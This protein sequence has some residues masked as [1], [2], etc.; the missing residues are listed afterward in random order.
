MF[1]DL[2]KVS[3]SDALSSDVKCDRLRWLYWRGLAGRHKA[4]SGFLQRFASISATAGQMA[5]CSHPLPVELLLDRWAFPWVPPSCLGLGFPRTANEIASG[6]TWFRLVSSDRRTHDLSRQRRQRCQ[7][8]QSGRACKRDSLPPPTLESGTAEPTV[9]CATGLF[10]SVSSSDH[11][12]RVSV[13]IGGIC[14]ILPLLEIFAKACSKT[15]N[16]SWSSSWDLLP[17]LDGR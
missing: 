10:E 1:A 3:D 17:L 2:L 4:L 6:E 15:C 9:P 13:R 14:L 7:D 16:G 5:N 12:G 11:D 8:N